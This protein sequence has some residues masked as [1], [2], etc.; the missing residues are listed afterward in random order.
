MLTLALTGCPRPL[1]PDRLDFDTD[2]RILRGAY[3]G[4]VDTRSVPT[5]TALAGNASLLATGWPDAVDLWHPETAEPIATL[6]PIWDE[7]IWQVALSVDGPGTLVA[8]I[9][10]GALGLWSGRDG[11]LIRTFDL[12]ERP[13]A[14][15]ECVLE[16]LA[17][18]PAGETLAVGGR[19]PYVLVLDT[20]TGA[21]VRELETG[22]D[23]AGPIAFSAD[24]TLLVS[25][26][27]VSAAG[28]ALRVWDTTTYEVVF[29]REG[30]LGWS[31]GPQFAFSADG[32]RLAVGSAD[33][34]E[35][36]DIAGGATE[37]S[38]GAPGETW[39]QSLSPDGTQV[40]LASLTPQHDLY[41]VTVVDA[42]TGGPL[43]RFPHTR[44]GT[45]L[46]STDGRFLIAG[47]QLA[48]AND[49]SVVR[50][51]AVGQYYALELAATAQYVNARKYAVSGTLSIDGGAGIEVS[52][53]VDGSDSQRY[54]QP[55]YGVPQ[56]AV[57]RLELRDRP[58]YLRAWQYSSAWHGSMDE[59]VAEEALATGRFELWRTP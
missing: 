36:F 58:W 2:P 6:D 22:G 21:L 39:L 30:P 53:I 51:Y 24:G 14:C 18:S 15:D 34:V 31:R 32:R 56:P 25:A 48:G 9:V 47:S 55:Q 13:A 8:G 35:L 40:G 44:S 54:L 37:L 19:T 28:Y 43:A 7:E 5:A 26:S 17:L 57:L 46:W 11:R 10:N 38:L 42:A 50:D 4:F 59:I 29:E 20:T 41:T 52:G 16:R 12:G 49:F 27:S 23:E 1:R 45:S 33:K 3:L